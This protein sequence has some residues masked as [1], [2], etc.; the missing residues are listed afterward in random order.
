M[1]HRYRCRRLCCF[2][3]LSAWDAG[4]GLAYSQHQCLVEASSPLH[5]VQVQYLTYLLAR[6]AAGW[7]GKPDVTFGHCL[8]RAYVELAAVQVKAS[9]RPRLICKPCSD[10]RVSRAERVG[11]FLGDDVR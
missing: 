11:R 9:N 6:P 3:G 8:W 7:L 5:L 10:L 1:L 4:Q 2:P